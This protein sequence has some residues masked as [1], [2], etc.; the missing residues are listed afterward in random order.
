MP[1]GEI[2]EGSPLARARSLCLAFPETEQAGQVACPDVNDAEDNHVMT[3][4][5]N[6]HKDRRATVSYRLS[7]S[8]SETV[9]DSVWPLA[10]PKEAVAQ[11]ARDGDDQFTLAPED[12][13]GKRGFSILRRH[14]PPLAGE[15]GVDGRSSAGCPWLGRRP[16]GR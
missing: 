1:R 9:S 11:V 4:S 5:D 6:Y 3:P 16:C 14:G 2:Q 15:S 10:R 8:H 13:F 12:V 7:G